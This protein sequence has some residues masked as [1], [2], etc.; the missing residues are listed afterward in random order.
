MMRET[1]AKPVATQVSGDDA[2]LQAQVKAQ[3]AEIREA[4]RIEAQRRRDA[5]AADRASR[6]VSGST[7]WDAGDKRA[8]PAKPLTKRQRQR[9]AS[10][11]KAKAPGMVEQL[12]T[13]EARAHGTYVEQTVPGATIVK[14][15]KE[16]LT[17]KEVVLNRGGT[18]VE[19]WFMN[20]RAGLFGE[21]QQR[22]VHYCRA[23]WHRAS[24]LSA[25]DPT[26]ERLD[27]QDGL[28][29]QEALD[30]LYDLKKRVPA[31]YW[32]VFENV[33]RF[34]QEAGVAGSTI[35]NNKRSAVDAAKTC[36]A[37]TAS[38]VAQWR[39]L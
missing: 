35:A 30:E 26:T 20:D 11:A 29:Q 15:G 10:A 21:P 4:N 6:T 33:C 17:T 34:D 22:A 13:P 36:V 23:L 3:R 2:D 16:I 5:Q 9:A 7:V 39:R 31:T 25:M 18:A 1:I 24:G 8:E 38:L 27:C 14:G 37:F 32:G 19:R 12:V 28:S